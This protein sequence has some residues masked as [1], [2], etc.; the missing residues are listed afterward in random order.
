MRGIKL[1]IAGLLV[2]GALAPAVALAASSPTATTGPATNVSSDSAVLTGTVAPHGAA[3]TY[4][5]RYGTSSALG[6]QT[7]SKRVGPDT[8][9]VT[10]TQLFDGL[11]PGTTYYY[12]LA[13]LN[14]TGAAAG[15][16]RTL[17][18]PGTPPAAVTGTATAIRSTTATVNGTVDA[19][20]AATS[21]Q[22]QYGTVSGHFTS[23]PPA[24]GWR[25]GRPSAAVS[26]K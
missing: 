2:L 9:R 1:L 17:K 3:T 8:K 4:A 12:Q 25:C 26:A 21:W 11:S 18:T 14:S 24:P 7:P 20:G 5:F 16:I 19:N 23:R 15:R 10:T 13:A 6:Y 22:V